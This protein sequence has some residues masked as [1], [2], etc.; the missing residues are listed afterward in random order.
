VPGQ[1]V[2]EMFNIESDQFKPIIGA[3]L[4]QEEAERL[5]A[6]EDTQDTTGEALAP[7]LPDQ[8][9]P[10]AESEPPDSHSGSGE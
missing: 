1:E 4:I 7:L 9:G 2:I 3:R 8:A 5:A 10:Q 6:Q